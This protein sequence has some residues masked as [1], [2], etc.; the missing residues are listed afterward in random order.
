[1]A[2]QDETRAF[3]EAQRVERGLSPHTI[4]A[5]EGDLRAF[6]EHVAPL[7]ATHAERVEVRHIRR[8]LADH[9]DALARSTLARRLSALRSFLRWCAKEGRCAQNVGVL[10]RSPKLERALARHLSV[11]EVFRLLDEAPDPDRPLELRNTAMFELTYSCGLRVGELVSLDIDRL[12]L[13]EGW[14]RVYG[15]GNRERDVPVGGK[16]R[17]ALRA[18]LAARPELLDRGPDVGEAALFLNARGG[19]LSARSVRRHLD[20][21][22][23]WRGMPR[24]VSPHGLRHSFATHLLD[25]GADLRSIQQLL[26]HAQLATTERYTHVSIAHL[27]KVYDRAHPRGKRATKE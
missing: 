20:K 1:M 5:Y 24:R 21:A 4:R 3:L 23:R 26:G 12:D 11:D 14:V 15:K 25:G 18:Y 6:F 13:A 19:R 2:W 8:Y 9:I 27:M 22:Q 17:E 7:G 10:V 16:A